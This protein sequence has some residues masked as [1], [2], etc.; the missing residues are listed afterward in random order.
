MPKPT[1]LRFHHRPPY[2]V[3]ATARGAQQ[4]LVLCSYK[5][6]R[7]TVVLHILLSPSYFFILFLFIIRALLHPASLR[8]LLSNLSRFDN[9]IFPLQNL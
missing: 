4:T 8:M 5:K 7:F 6:P 1:P 9:T 2:L 3:V